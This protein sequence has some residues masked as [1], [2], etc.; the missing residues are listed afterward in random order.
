ML[1]HPAKISVFF[2]L[3]SFFLFYTRAE[4]FQQIAENFKTIWVKVKK[5]KKHC[6]VSMFHNDIIKSKMNKIVFECKCQRIP[7]GQNNI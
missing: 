7:K 2:G 3:A 5:S 1:S 6:D 4:K